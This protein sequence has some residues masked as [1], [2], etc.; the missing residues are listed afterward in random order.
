[1]LGTAHVCGP[2]ALA[3][4][5]SI[6]GGFR[7]ELQLWCRGHDRA[8]GRMDTVIQVPGRTES[9]ASPHIERA[10]L[11]RVRA[12]HGVSH[13]ALGPQAPCGTH[14]GMFSLHERRK[15]VNI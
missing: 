9:K 7:L 6:D 12:S 1:M 8:A 2:N 13:R 5:R 4:R 15:A 11:C 14:V 10:V 3:R